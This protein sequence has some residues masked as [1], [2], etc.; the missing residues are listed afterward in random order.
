MD[1]SGN[2]YRI[3]FRP[4]VPLVD[5]TNYKMKF[6]L[7]LQFFRLFRVISQNHFR[8]RGTWWGS[9]FDFKF[10]DR[11]ENIRRRRVRY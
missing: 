6:Y 8:S 1:G 7:I 11:D 2:L 3:H 10:L 5:V 9:T 4:T